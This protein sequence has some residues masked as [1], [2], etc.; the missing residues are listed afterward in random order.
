[1]PLPASYL[2]HG[3]RLLYLGAVGLAW[4]WAALLLPPGRR[5][6][7]EGTFGVI[8]LVLT[9]VLGGFMVR[10]RLS[11]YAHLGDPVHVA[12]EV[13]AGRPPEEGL[14]LVNLPQWVAPRQ[15]VYP[16]GVEL[17]AVLGDYLFVEELVA[18]NLDQ[19]RPVKA[20]VAPDLLVERNYT[21]ALH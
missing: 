21:Y 2:L 11:A 17:A 16:L 7:V 10:N 3:P 6:R 1:V 19:D 13:L 15:G 20:W 18:L 9:L 12:S 5:S 14:L 8:A 4:I